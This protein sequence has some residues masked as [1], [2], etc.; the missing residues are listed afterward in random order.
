[1]TKTS[2]PSTRRRLR[3]TFLSLLKS[4][5]KK[6]EPRKRDALRR[7]PLFVSIYR[8]ALRSLV[9]VPFEGSELLFAMR[10]FK[11]YLDPED[12][13]GCLSY[14]LSG[15]YEPA[16]TA[17]FEQVLSDGDTVIDV[18]AHWGYYTLLSASLC[19]DSGRVFAFEPHPGNFALL[20]RSIEANA[21]ANVVAVQKAVS[22]NVGEGKLFLSKFSV[23]HSIRCIPGYWKM[24]PGQEQDS[25]NVGVTSLDAFY[26]KDLPKPRII[27]LDVEGAEP[28]AFRGMQSLMKATASLVLIA[29][30]N[31]SYLDP[32]SIADFIAA[33]VSCG[34]E[35]GV[36]DD[37]QRQIY[38]GRASTLLDQVLRRKGILNIL[39]T[40]D[41][42]VMSSLPALQEKAAGR[43]VKR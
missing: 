21:F 20:T 40:R 39:A 2:Q 36:I 43:R 34:C 11:M 16:T 9:K 32:D 19:G 30:C 25:L 13:T 42:M 4:S 38:I 28:L 22:E 14:Y 26:P 10:G 23:G 33:L 31:P 18:G 17:V 37:D 24:S 5:V 41:G 15:N 27:K 35:I 7:I 6:I 1:M 3:K 12:D 8:A 29:E